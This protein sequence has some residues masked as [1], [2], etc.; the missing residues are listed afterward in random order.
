MFSHPVPAPFLSWRRSNMANQWY[1]AH[2]GGMIGP[3]SGRQ[4]RELA[5][6]GGIVP[7]DTVWKEGVEKGA[8]ASKVKNLFPLAAAAAPIEASPPSPRG[9]PV[10]ARPP[11]LAPAVA[12][13]GVT[14]PQAK[15]P[16]ASQPGPQQ[17]QARMGR[18]MAVRGAVIVGQDGVSVKYKKK[19]TVCGHADSF[20]HTMPIRN[21]ACKATYFCPKCRKNRD[22]EI[23]GSL[24]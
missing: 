9:E 4:L 12:T 20:S 1:Y 19:C 11:D 2:G 18:A 5:A 16:G 23:K 15:V 22:V 8:L 3:Y 17:G 6:S 13:L 24:S 7:T 21:G 10:P 14:S